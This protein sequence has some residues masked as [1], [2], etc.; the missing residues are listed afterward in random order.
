MSRR[1][2]GA[3]VSF[4]SQMCLVGDG[5]RGSQPRPTQLERLPDLLDEMREGHGRW[6]S[7]QSLKEH[8]ARTLELARGDAM[9]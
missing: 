8:K 9:L 7:A 4:W 6:G 1:G 3:G 2:G 5:G